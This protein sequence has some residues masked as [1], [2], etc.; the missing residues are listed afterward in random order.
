MPATKHTSAPTSTD[1]VTVAV[2]GVEQAA[3]EE[4][5]DF[6]MFVTAA[7]KADPVRHASEQAGLRR[8]FRKAEANADHALEFNPQKAQQGGGPF[9]YRGTLVAHDKKLRRRSR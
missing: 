9:S 7:E 1:P 6:D 5:L 3:A 4:G 2:E 8:E